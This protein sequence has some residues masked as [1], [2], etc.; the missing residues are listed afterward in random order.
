MINVE[1]PVSPEELLQ[2]VEHLDSPAAA[3]LLEKADPAAAMGALRRMGAQAAGDILTLLPAPA[4]T[5]VTGA[6][7][8]EVRAQWELNLTFPRGSVGRLMDPAWAV[9]PPE[10]TAR[11]TID[12]LRDMVKKEFITYAYVADARKKLVGVV[13]MRDLL[14]AGPAKPLSEIMLKNPF[15]LKAAEPLMDAMRE[16]LNRHFPVYPVTNPDGELIGAVRG[17]RLFEAQAIEISA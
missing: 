10:T 3:K 14:F 4:K 16:V 7:P 2:A 11:E 12:A 15:S 17:G 5:A 8:A 9:F 1:T 13:V 6:L